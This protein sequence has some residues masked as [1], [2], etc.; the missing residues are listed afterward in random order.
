MKVAFGFS[1]KKMGNVSLQ[2]I[3]FLLKENHVKRSTVT[4]LFEADQ[5]DPWG[6]ARA[7]RSELGF[8]SPPSIQPLP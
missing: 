2:K 8:G 5:V 1:L 7:I 4:L 3:N 6:G